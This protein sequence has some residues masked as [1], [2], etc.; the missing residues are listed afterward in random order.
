MP[1]QIFSLAPAPGWMATVTSGRRIN[2]IANPSVVRVGRGLRMG[3]AVDASK[4]RIVGGVGMA[5]PA[6][7]PDLVMPAGVDREPAMRGSGAG[8]GGG[9]VA[10]RARGR[11]SG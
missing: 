9:S 4:Y 8:P 2:V 11:V 6:S 7:G 1:H 5:I 3:V 10:T